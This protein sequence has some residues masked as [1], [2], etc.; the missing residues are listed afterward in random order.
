MILDETGAG[1]VLVPA[2]Q[3]LL[4]SV[5]FGLAPNWL[6][7]YTLLRWSGGYAELTDNYLKT[8][9]VITESD[10]G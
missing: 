4:Q 8:V 7:L 3:V 6:A 5:Y 9:M 2:L 1:R 10:I